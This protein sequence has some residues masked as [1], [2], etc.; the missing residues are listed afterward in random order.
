MQRLRT[1]KNLKIIVSRY[2][3]N[4][5]LDDETWLFFNDLLKEIP[6]KTYDQ[7]NFLRNNHF[8]EIKDSLYYYFVHIK[9][10]MVKEGLSPIDF[11]KERIAEMI[12]NRRKVE[13]LKKM[14]EEI[15]HEATL[16]GKIE[17]Y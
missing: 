11:E 5:Y 6:I 9:D 10:F 1:F 2:A 14:Q 16:K 3:A 15:Y 8:I 7:E 4:Y 13:L 17:V 12:V